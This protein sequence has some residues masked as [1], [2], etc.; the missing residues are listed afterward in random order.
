MH[1][2]Y[3]GN[4][5]STILTGIDTIQIQYV[6]E[7]MGL[8]KRIINYKNGKD[9]ALNIIQHFKCRIIYAGH[10]DESSWLWIWLEEPVEKNILNFLKNN[11]ILVNTEDFPVEVNYPF[12]EPRIMELSLV[13]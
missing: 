5:I 6:F 13:K 4:F 2:S 9:S 1:N 11:D 8:G 12:K 3:I 10:G 7:G